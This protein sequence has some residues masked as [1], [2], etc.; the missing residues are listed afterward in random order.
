MK[1][2]D[3]SESTTYCT[4]KKKTHILD[5]LEQNDHLPVKVKYGSA[6]YQSPLRQE[7]TPV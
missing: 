3:D 4:E 5:Y 6:W 2:D 7:K 1:K